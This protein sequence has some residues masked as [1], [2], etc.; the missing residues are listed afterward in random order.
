M[1]ALTKGSGRGEDG[2]T[3]SPPLHLPC[4]DKAPGSESLL[5][6]QRRSD[7]VHYLGVNLTVTT[8]RIFRS[9]PEIFLLTTAFSVTRP[10]SLVVALRVHRDCHRRHNKQD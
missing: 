3:T 4:E 10:S 5:N 8:F 7:R 9:R 2:R 1:C 6:C